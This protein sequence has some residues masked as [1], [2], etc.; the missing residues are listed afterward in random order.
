MLFTFLPQ[1]SD[2]SQ[3]HSYPFSLAAAVAQTPVISH[4]AAAATKRATVSRTSQKPAPRKVE[5]DLRGLVAGVRKLPAQQRP[6]IGS[7]NAMRLLKIK[8]RA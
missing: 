8:D 3:R 1:F 4:R 7:F 2:P 5:K 6:Q